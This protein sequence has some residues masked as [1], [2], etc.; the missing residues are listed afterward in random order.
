LDVFGPVE[1]F[2]I[3]IDLYRI[4][5][6][7]L[8]GGLIKNKHGV[9]ILTEKMDL[10]AKA[11]IFLIPGGIGTRTEVNNKQLLSKIIELAQSSNYVLTVCTGS[12]LLAKTGLL[13]NRYA[14]SNKL[15]FPWVIINGE[16][17]N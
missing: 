14:T 7:S 15:W 5:F 2:G 9:S 17:V 10:V 4:K 6:Y 3:L 1:I 13:D 12:A 16:Q 11:E 8:N